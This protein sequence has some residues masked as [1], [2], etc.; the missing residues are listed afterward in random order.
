[1]LV[2]AV[3]TTENSLLV[4]VFMSGIAGIMTLFSSATGVVFPTLY[5]MVKGIHEVTGLAP[6]LLFT[7]IASGSVFAGMSPLSACGALIMGCV[8][9]NEIKKI[10]KNLFIVSGTGIVFSMFL[11]FTATLII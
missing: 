6:G 8:S 4:P 1:M 10:Y 11:S 5:P 7:V 3:R 9:E 2:H